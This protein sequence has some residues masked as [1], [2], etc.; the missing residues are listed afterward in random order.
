MKIL[1]QGIALMLSIL[2]CI[3]MAGCGS[4]DKIDE[5]KDKQYQFTVMT[6][7]FPYYDFAR[8]IVGEDSD[9]HVEL[10]MSP[11]QDSHSYEPIP[12]DILAIDHADMF[13]YNG[14][15]MEKWVEEV[16]DSLENKSQV[17]MRMMDEV[18]VLREEHEGAEEI[19][20]K[21]H[22]H[23]EDEHED[24]HNQEEVDEHIWTSPVYAMILTQKIC[25]RLCEMMPEKE[26]VFRNNA[27]NYINK[28]KNI[29]HQFT[30]IVNNAKHREMIF[31]DKFPLKYFAHEY[32]LKYYAA[33]PGCS[34]DTEPSAKTVAFLIN[35][36]KA[37]AV[38]G[39]FYLEL[40]SQA[41]ADVICD[42][43][44][45][46]KYPFNSCHNI[47]QKQFDS[48]I[49]YIDLMQENVAVLKAALN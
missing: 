27:E 43:T 39:I 49:T 34:G 32:G 29:D 6:T 17:Q 37:R 48:G 13:I 3:H 30:E 19:Y 36:V 2:L 1:K 45:V 40:S 10:L 14:G 21:E 22:H 31:A 16:I 11:G 9:I 35:K 33:F 24:A 25:D 28:L 8:A 38:H 26:T 20:A 41:M 7:L 42:D 18:N 4:T 47:T 46:K 44:G 23:E 12:S 15:S 5:K